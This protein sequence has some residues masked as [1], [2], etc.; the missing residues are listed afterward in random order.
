MSHKQIF[1][2]PGIYISRIVRDQ[3]METAQPEY[4]PEWFSNSQA[5]SGRGIDS[6]L[7]HSAVGNLT[8]ALGPLT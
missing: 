1:C 5:A 4:P 3:A 2:N 6:G 7:Y 8:E